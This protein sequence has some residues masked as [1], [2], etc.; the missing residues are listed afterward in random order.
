[1]SVNACRQIRAPISGQFYKLIARSY[2]RGL[3]CSRTIIFTLYTAMQR[4]LS[5]LK[6]EKYLDIFC[7]KRPIEET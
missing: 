3:E 5:K 6:G 7:S 1:M 2:L 4:L